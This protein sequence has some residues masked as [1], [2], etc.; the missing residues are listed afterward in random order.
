MYIHCA[1]KAVI[2]A[3]HLEDSVKCNMF[4]TGCSLDSLISPCLPLGHTVAYRLRGDI[5]YLKSQPLIWDKKKTDA[6]KVEIRV[7]ALRSG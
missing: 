6:R 7:K 5:I 1:L 2:P 4:V 3:M